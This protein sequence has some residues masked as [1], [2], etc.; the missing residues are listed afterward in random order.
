[1]KRWLS[2]LLVTLCTSAAFAEA[3][4]SSLVEALVKEQ[5]LTPLSAGEGKRKRFSR[6][7]PPPLARRVRVLDAERVVLDSRGKQFVRFAVD[8]RHAWDEDGVWQEASLTGC[9]YL[10]ERQVFLF[11]GEEYRAA[12]AMVGKRQKEKQKPAGVCVS[13]ADAQS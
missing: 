3:P 7:A 9:A 2:L 11:D 12:S 1:M 6:A 8:V 10:D 5:Y 13:S 4:T